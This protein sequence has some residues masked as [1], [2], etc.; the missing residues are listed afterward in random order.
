MKHD[1]IANK[2]NAIAF[3]QTAYLGNPRAAVDQY[4]GAEY[5]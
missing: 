3:Y 4:V 5:I 1:L 2:N